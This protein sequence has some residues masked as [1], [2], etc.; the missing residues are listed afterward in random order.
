MPGIR[1]TRTNSSGRHAGATRPHTSAKRTLASV[2]VAVVL[3]VALVASGCTAPSPSPTGPTP[4]PPGNPYAG[5][6]YAGNPYA[7]KD[8][9]ALVD[10]GG[11]R[12]IW[13]ECTGRGSPTVVLM[14]G[15]G[16]GA[17]DWSLILDPD[18]PAHRSPTDDVSA[19]LGELHRSDRAVLPSVARTSRVCTYDRPDIRWDD[20]QVT[21]PRPQPHT[22]D[23]DVSDLHAL[24][25]AIGETGPVVLAAHSY[26]GLVATLYARTHPDDV[27]GLVMVDTASEVLEQ[28]V[29]PGAL[30]RWDESNATT[31]DAVR[32]GVLVKDAFAR[33]NAAG[34]LP[35]VPSIVLVADKPWRTDLVP[36]EDLEGEHTTF[37][38]WLAMGTELGVRLGAKKTLTATNSGHAVYL[39]EPALV[40]SSIREVVEDVRAG[41][42]NQG[43]SVDIGGGRAMYIEC[44][45]TGS[46]TVVLV[47]GLQ[48]AGDLWDSPLGKSPTVFPSVGHRTRVCTYDRPGAARA[49]AAG[50][51]SRSTPVP[52]PAAPSDAV[53]DLH[54]LLGAAGES[55]PYVLV[56]HSFGG[57]IARMFANAHPAEVKGMV[58]LD[59]FS[60]ELRAGFTDEEWETWKTLNT[61][62]PEVIEDY[63]DVERIAF[64]QAVQQ[65]RDG[66]SIPPMPLVVI[67]A[68]HPTDTTGAPGVPDGFGELIDRVHRAAQGKVAQLVPG[69]RWITRSHSGHN[70]MLDQP[71]L[72]T[73][74][75]LDVVAAVREGR[76]A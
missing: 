24:L 50:G 61:T 40:A 43:R 12:T 55:G 68:D 41:G 49:Q 6:P 64:D 47:S 53:A 22:A 48:V 59:S 7:G 44:R 30:D 11:G 39:Y 21:T 5:N 63:P 25:A 74:V 70:V 18:D 33:I 37:D 42:A 72:V 67:T 8:F 51:F 2:G 29:T 32:E 76:R 54:A 10:V 13:T 19:G 14:S 69:A 60:P 9:A 4:E 27:A 56:A 46:P 20:E 1:N 71:Q 15:K 28:L 3:L 34:P 35:D 23:L 38:D 52:Q 17:E 62:R 73:D 16:N 57:V 75:T 36:P 31:N 65:G 66:G 26:S 58:L 45:G